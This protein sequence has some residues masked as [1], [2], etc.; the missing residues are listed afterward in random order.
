MCIRD[1]TYIGACEELAKHCATT[2]VM[3]SAHSSLCCWPISEYGTEAQKEKYLSKLCSGEWLGA[4]GLTEPGAGT[5]AAMQLSL[6]HICAAGNCFPL[7][8]NRGRT[9]S[10]VPACRLEEKRAKSERPRT[11][12]CV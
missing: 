7:P 5:D 11:S 1:S 2:S 12:R 10:E 9:R 4:F 3:V 6:I 8:R